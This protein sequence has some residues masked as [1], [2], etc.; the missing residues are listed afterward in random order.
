MKRAT[1]LA[2]AFSMLGCWSASAQSLRAMDVPP[3]TMPAFEAVTIT[4]SMGLDPLGGPVWRNGRYVL[5]ATDR[6]G[7]ELRVVLDAG[8]GHVI[9]VRPVLTN[10]YEPGPGFADPRAPGPR[11]AP[12]YGGR[13]PSYSP[14]YPPGGYVTED[15]EVAITTP[16][17]DPREYQRGP[18]SRQQFTTRTPVSEKPAATAPAV[19]KKEPAA[20][21]AK[22]TPVPTP[23]PKAK[24]DVVT[25]HEGSVKAAEKTASSQ[26]ATSGSNAAEKKEI[27]KIEIDRKPEETKP[28]ETKP[29]KKDDVPVNP[30]L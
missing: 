18:V 11:Y 24:D 22:V 8:T 29:E 5:R 15:D 12:V 21:S 4:R 9:A 2:T 3:G 1:I 20:Q 10:Y 16:R 14:S 17:V 28:A 7:R 23:A 25:K 19:K 30:L 13:G 27:R 6:D 26:A